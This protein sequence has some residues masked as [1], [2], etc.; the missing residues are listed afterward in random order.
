MSYLYSLPM[1]PKES[2]FIT[3]DGLYVHHLNQQT[4]YCEDPTLVFMGLPKQVIP[5]P[6]FQ[7]TASH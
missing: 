2:G 5:F 1:F 7:K 6:T 4:F 3:D